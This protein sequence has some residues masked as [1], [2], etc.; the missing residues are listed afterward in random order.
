MKIEPIDFTTYADDLKT[1]SR[2]YCDN[3][4]S[5]DGNYRLE[6]EYAGEYLRGDSWHYG[7]IIQ[8]DS[9]QTIW[10][11]KKGDPI[12]GTIEYPWSADSRCCY[13]TIINY[14]DRIMQYD[15]LTGKLKTIFGSKVQNKLKG[16]SFVPRNFNGLVFF[17]NAHDDVEQPDIYCYRHDSESYIKLN[18]QVADERFV[19]SECGIQDSVVF[20]CRDT[21]KLFDVLQ[22][23]VVEQFPIVG[24]DFSEFRCG[25]AHYLPQSDAIYFGIFTENE[26]RHYRLYLGQ[27]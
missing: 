23:K 24:S 5:P 12:R 18:D 10:E 25:H 27:Y 21:I 16:I 11:Y 6:L 13:F 9:G 3:Y 1:N 22:R 14:G 8:S 2:H 26:W 15:V 17:D 7:R 20:I 4:P 19:I